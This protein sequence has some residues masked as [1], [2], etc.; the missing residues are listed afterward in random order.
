LEIEK[1]LHS[2]IGPK[3]IHLVPTLSVVNLEKV[4]TVLKEQIENPESIFKTD[5]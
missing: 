5:F 3:E 2:F 4:V 1:K